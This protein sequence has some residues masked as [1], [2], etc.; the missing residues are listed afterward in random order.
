M[1]NLFCLSWV[2]D[3]WT[4]NIRLGLWLGWCMGW[5]ASVWAADATH[6]YTVLGPDRSAMLRS[7]SSDPTCPKARWDNGSETTLQ[8]R[9]RPVSLPPRPDQVQPERIDTD[10]PVWV[11]ETPWPSNATAVQVDGKHL[12]GPQE[13][14]QKILILGDSGCRLKATENAFQDCHDPKAWPF[15]ALTKL[16]ARLQPD[17]V[18]HMGDLHYRESPCPAHQSGCADS[19][20][21]YGWTAWRADFFEPAQPLMQVPWIWVRGNHESCLRAGQGWMRFLDPRPF[22][23]VLSCDDP[24][25]DAQADFT[26]PYVVALNDLTRVWVF[27]SSR[28]SGKTPPQGDAVAASHLAQLSALQSAPAS[29]FNVFVSHHPHDGLIGTAQGTTRA[30]G[31]AGLQSVLRAA[32]GPSMLPDQFQLTLHGHLHVFE[33]LVAEPG[34]ASTV[35]LGNSGSMMEAKPPVQVASDR[36]MAHGARLQQWVSQPGYGFA[37]L[38]HLPHTPSTQWL[39]TEFNVQGQAVAQCQLSPQIASCLP[40]SPSANR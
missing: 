13:A 35:I 21:G 31:T 9:S 19:P 22:Q 34:H 28:A 10:F 3:R 33:A 29:A 2:S 26:P 6:V 18:M 11:C 38:E 7:I 32:F 15:P 4:W 30:A 8:V 36:R 17:L 16:A 37:M 23:P 39:L 20:W 14:Y 24:Q 27:D 40:M 25:H 5:G 12:Q 1:K